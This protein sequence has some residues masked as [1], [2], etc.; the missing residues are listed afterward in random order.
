[1]HAFPPPRFRRIVRL[2]ADTSP[3]RMDEA[4]RNGATVIPLRR[5]TASA[6]T[7]SGRT[8]AGPPVFGRTAPAREDPAHEQAVRTRINMVVGAVLVLLLVS[9]LWL[10]D[11]LKQI[12]TIQDC[13]MQGRRNC[14]PIAAPPREPDAR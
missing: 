3:R 8:A 12:S 2:V 14:A 4:P 13:V 6:L 10:V 7:A 11:R 1:M 5:P 9:G